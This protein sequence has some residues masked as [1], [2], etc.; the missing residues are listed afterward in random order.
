MYISIH[1]YVSFLD[2]LYLRQ[3]KG[4]I[5]IVIF[6]VIVTNSTLFLNQQNLIHFIALSSDSV[7]MSDQG[8]V[9]EK[10]F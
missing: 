8:T 9:L 2:E 1:M 5:H 10:R 3:C 7:L 6:F 4:I